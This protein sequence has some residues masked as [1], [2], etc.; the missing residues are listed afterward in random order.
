MQIPLC[1]LH[2]VGIKG[3]DSVTV[4]IDGRCPDQIRINKHSKLTREQKNTHKLKASRTGVYIPQDLITE[5]KLDINL[6]L[7]IKNGIIVVS[8]G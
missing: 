8:N 4:R 2:D 1:V 7:E 3:G 5:A 6:K